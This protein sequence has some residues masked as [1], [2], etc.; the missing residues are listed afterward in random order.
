M[1]SCLVEKL[2]TLGSY[3]QPIFEAVSDVLGMAYFDKNVQFHDY[4]IDTGR[5]LK[6]YSIFHLDPNIRSNCTT[7]QD[8]FLQ[9][10]LDDL[11]KV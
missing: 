7:A 3:Q 8:I 11:R 10:G 1:P 6:M 4:L 2:D 9:L 5:Y